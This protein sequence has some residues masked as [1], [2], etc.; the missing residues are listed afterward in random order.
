MRHWREVSGLE[1]LEVTYE[2]L[3]RDTATVSRRMIEFLG[4]RRD[5]SCLRYFE[6]GV[7]T[8]AAGTPLHEP[9]DAREVGWHERYRPYIDLDAFAPDGG[10]Q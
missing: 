6:P 8:L 7:A 5:E 3:V 1:M 9:I 10:A 2:E 4:L